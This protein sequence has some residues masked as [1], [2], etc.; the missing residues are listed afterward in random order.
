MKNWREAKRRRRERERSWRATKRGVAGARRAKRWQISPRPATTPRWEARRAE[1]GEE[2]EGESEDEEV[3]E[4]E[5]E[6][7]EES[8][9]PGWRLA[10][11]WP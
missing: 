3:A 8:A 1:Q 7:E 4:E 5:D 10:A 2:E 9:R 11:R 6:K